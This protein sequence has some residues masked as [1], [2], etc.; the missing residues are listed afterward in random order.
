MAAAA[1]KTCMNTLASAPTTAATAASTPSR[2]T[3]L[4]LTIFLTEDSPAFCGLQQQLDNQASALSDIAASLQQLLA[5]LRNPEPRLPQPP[6]SQPVAAIL[7]SATLPA[8]NT[9]G[10]VL[11]APLPGESDV[12]HIFS[13]LSREVVQQVINNT[14]P[15]Q[16]LG[17]LHNPDSPLVNDKHKHAVLVNSILIKSIPSAVS[18][19]STCHFTKLIPDV[20]CFAKAWTIYTCIQA[21][22]INNPNLGTSLGAFLLHIIQNNHMHTWPLVVSY[23][24]TTC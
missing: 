16:D 7:T 19:S 23:V 24:L 15:L 17:R 1:C 18:T 6:S 21:C 13:W 2:R 20:H 8:A 4:P 3:P 22:A 10:S 11:G 9:A 5:L 12:D 14:L